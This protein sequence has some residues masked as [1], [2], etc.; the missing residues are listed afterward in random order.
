M[1]IISTSTSTWTVH[2]NFTVHRWLRE[3]PRSKL[4][5]GKDFQRDWHS[6]LAGR[7]L[8]TSSHSS[9]RVFTMIGLGSFL[10][11]EAAYF[12]GKRSCHPS[13]YVWY[14]GRLIPEKDRSGGETWEREAT[15]W[16][17]ISLVSNSLWIIR[18]GLILYWITNQEKQFEIILQAWLYKSYDS[19]HVGGR[20]IR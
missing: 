16:F 6:L 20:W 9:L 11:M 19:P 10:L 18:M 1:W 7:F 5:K 13:A 4:L 14:S 12:R 3:P 2:N 8:Q 15:V 17:W